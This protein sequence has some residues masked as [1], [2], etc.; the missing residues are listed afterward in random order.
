MDNDK[1]F[2]LAQILQIKP[3]RVWLFGGDD[4]NIFFR[5]GWI[6]QKHVIF[7]DEQ[8]DGYEKLTN[9]KSMLVFDRR[10]ICASGVD[11][12]DGRISDELRTAINSSSYF[13]RSPALPDEDV[14]VERKRRIM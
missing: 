5:H 13:A 14:A 8:P 3:L 11:L 6:K 9:A 4:A 2:I 10:S 12:V 7:Q 1:L